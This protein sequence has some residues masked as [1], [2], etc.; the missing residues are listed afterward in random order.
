MCSSFLTHILLYSI[1]NYLISHCI[2]VINKFVAENL[3]TVLELEGSVHLLGPHRFFKKSETKAFFL[4][5]FFPAASLA[6]LQFQESVD[7]IC[8]SLSAFFSHL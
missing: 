5:E 6:F 4:K 1:F 7:L 8:A 2:L 3:V